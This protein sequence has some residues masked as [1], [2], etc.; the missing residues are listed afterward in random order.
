MP[1]EQKGS[2]AL[3]RND[4]N[5]KKLMEV[6][7]GHLGKQ[8]FLLQRADWYNEK[9]R[10]LNKNTKPGDVPITVEAAF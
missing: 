6:C 8:E 3:A 1:K 9:E 10:E 5:L 4:E 7:Q 2:P